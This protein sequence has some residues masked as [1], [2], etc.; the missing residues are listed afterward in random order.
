M[1]A[2]MDG[3]VAEQ[4]VRTAQR[5]PLPKKVAPM[6]LTSFL[7]SEAGKKTTV[8]PGPLQFLYT[9]VLGAEHLRER[10]TW[11]PYRHDRASIETGVFQPWTLARREVAE[12]IDEFVRRGY[13][14]AL[15][16]SSCDGP[17][18]TEQDVRDLLGTRANLFG[19]WP[20]LET[21]LKWSEPS[22]YGF[23]EFVFDQVRRPRRASKCEKCQHLHF[24]EHV[25]LPARQLYAWRLNR[26]LA[27]YAMPLRLTLTGEDAGRLVTVPDDP[28]SELVDSLA[29]RDDVPSPERVRHAIGLFRARDATREDKRSAV[30]ALYT[31]AEEYRRPL[32]E[33]ALLRAEESSFF[34]LAHKYDIRHRKGH[35]QGRYDDAF[36][37]WY[38]WLALS[39]VEL[40]R[41]LLARQAET[42]R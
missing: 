6:D 2:F 24:S 39:T 10:P 14:P 38:F 27:A 19:V 12:L 9:L 18:K 33:T 17:Q 32:L 30:E 34:E 8:Y 11:R 37:D 31:I 3:D 29:S 15:S 13:L 1:E 7:P 35:Q 41:R 5:E 36:L 26:I 28:R 42:E 25:V 23:T 20:P 16:P 40:I 21:F 22:L 4:F